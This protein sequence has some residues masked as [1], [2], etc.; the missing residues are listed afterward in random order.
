MKFFHAD[1]EKNVHQ[2]VERWIYLLQY[3]VLITMFDCL[4]EILSTLTV[5]IENF[6][7]NNNNNNAITLNEESFNHSHVSKKKTCISNLLALYQPVSP[8][9]K[10]KQTIS[11]HQDK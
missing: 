5:D 10:N 1:T 7:N 2:F 3:M 4:S 8:S 6:N 9:V 11:N